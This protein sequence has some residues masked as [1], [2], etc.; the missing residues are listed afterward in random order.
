MR[1]MRRGWLRSVAI[2]QARQHLQATSY[3]RLHMSLIA[4]LTGA[5]GLLASFVLLAEGRDRP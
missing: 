1:L 4:A 5:F 3:P 2:R